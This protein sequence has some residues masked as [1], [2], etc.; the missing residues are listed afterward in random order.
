MG[1][2]DSLNLPG[3]GFESYSAEVAV[4][5]SVST[6]L[7]N[8]PTISPE[9]SGYMFEFR[10][11]D[12]DAMVGGNTCLKNDQ[13]LPTTTSSCTKAAHS[14]DAGFDSCEKVSTSKLSNVNAALGE[15]N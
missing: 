2:V 10:C 15:I 3:R 14:V 4:P 5:V 8:N 7:Q 9:T 1:N 11:T 13:A 12:V 6:P